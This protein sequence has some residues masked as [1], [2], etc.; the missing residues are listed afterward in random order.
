MLK[1]YEKL[2][3]V[4][5]AQEGCDSQKYSYCT[6]IILLYR[7]FPRLGTKYIK[8]NARFPGPFFLPEPPPSSAGSFGNAFSLALHRHPEERQAKNTPKHPDCPTGRPREQAGQVGVFSALPC[9]QEH[10]PVLHLPRGIAPSQ[11][12]SSDPELMIFRALSLFL[13]DKKACRNLQG[14]R[15]SQTVWYLLELM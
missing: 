9:N 1:D 14:V 7:H 6:C 3:P 2:Q 13:L 15:S 5:K 8:N 12:I 11:E 10:C 4:N